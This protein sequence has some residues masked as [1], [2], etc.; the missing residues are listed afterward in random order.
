METLTITLIKLFTAFFLST[1]F[2]LERQ[3]THKPVGFGT[4]IFVTLGSCALG[5]IAV[6]E[7]FPGSVSLL[8]AIVTGI[9]FLGAG[10][11]IKGTDKVFGFTTA[12]SIWLFSIL[13]LTIGIGEYVLGIAVYAF[14]WCTV[15]F[16]KYLER[17]GIG[18]FKKKLTVVTSGIFKEKIIRNDLLGLYTS[19]NTLLNVEINKTDGE[20][21][22]TYLIQGNRENINKLISE[23]YK[24]EWLKSAKID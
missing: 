11:L 24:Q 22:L 1:L 6:S 12:A 13:G 17:R 7:R 3:R 16:D 23:L 10:A 14:I 15:I 19:Q 21:K 4:F 8:S 20:M 18:S 2:G 5:L 9:G